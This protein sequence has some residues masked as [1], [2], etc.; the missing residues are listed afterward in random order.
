MRN[1][2]G[3]TLVELL[4]TLAILAII[5]GIAIPNVLSTLEKNR[6]TTYIEDAKKLVTLAEYE[7]N[8]DEELTV[9]SGCVRINLSY[10]DK[11]DLETGPNDGEYDTTNSYVIIGYDS[12]N[13]KYTYK[14]QLQ[15]RKNGEIKGGIGENNIDDLNADGAIANQALFK[16]DSGWPTQTTCTVTKS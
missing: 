6:K 16:K 14:V 11:T 5:M 1:D 15:E 3:F 2:K 7:F 9:D 13:H 8:K 4:A 10:L 12:T